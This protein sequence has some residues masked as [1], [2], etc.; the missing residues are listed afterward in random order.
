MCKMNIYLSDVKIGMVKPCVKTYA[1]SKPMSNQRSLDKKWLFVKGE[2]R[3]GA[4]AYG[5]GVHM[6]VQSKLIAPLTWDNVSNAAAWIWDI[7][8]SSRN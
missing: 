4:C 5:R 7:A 1:S 8:S 3:D 2:F 6:G